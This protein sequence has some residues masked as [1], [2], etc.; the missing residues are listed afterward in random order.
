[1]AMFTKLKCESVHD[2]KADGIS[3]FTCFF[4][5]TQLN[6][7]RVY[8]NWNK[9]TMSLS[10]HLIPQSINVLCM[11]I[12]ADKTLINFSYNAVADLRGARGTPPP[13]GA[14]ILSISCSFWENM[15]KSYVGAPPRGVGA[16]SSGKSWIR[17]CNEWID[18]ITFWRKIR[19]IR[20]KMTQEC[21]QSLDVPYPW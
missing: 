15:A 4:Y 20:S 13:G 9:Q 14:Q 17:H 6:M 8:V 21:F 1:M 5:K 2:V 18:Q 11:V 16:P 12:W 7:Y 10:I 19:S 3:Y